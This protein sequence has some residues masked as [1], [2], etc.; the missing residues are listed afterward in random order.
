MSGHPDHEQRRLDF[1]RKCGPQLRRDKVDLARILLCE[2]AR[3]EP[4]LFAAPNADELV[5]VGLADRDGCE[6]GL[7]VRCGREV[8]RQSQRF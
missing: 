5:F 8:L 7:D 3:L 4:P 2:R 1:A 6:H